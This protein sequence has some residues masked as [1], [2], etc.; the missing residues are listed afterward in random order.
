MLELYKEVLKYF[1]VL[2]MN[3]QTAIKRCPVVNPDITSFT[4][5]DDFIGYRP[6]SPLVTYDENM[7]EMSHNINYKSVLFSKD[8]EV[9]VM[10]K[11]ILLIHVINEMKLE[12][13]AIGFHFSRELLV[14]MSEISKNEHLLS[15][16]GGG[17]SFKKKSLKTFSH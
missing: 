7:E 1:D 4:L 13:D 11:T 16:W 3:C 17:E 8:V 2:S 10:D 12:R 5:A 9:S 15:V 6:L 14:F